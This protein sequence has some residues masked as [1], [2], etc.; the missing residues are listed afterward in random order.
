MAESSFEAYMTLA[1]LAVLTD[2]LRLGTAVSSVTHRHPAVLAKQVVTLDMVSGGRAVLGI[3]RGWAEDEHT[4]YGLP[5]GSA[6]QRSE[7]L[8]D[9]VS[10]CRSMFTEERSSFHGRHFQVVDAHNV[11]LPLSPFGPPI[12]I[13]GAGRKFTLPLVARFADIY[14]PGYGD[15]LLV[16]EVF[17]HLD[18]LCRQYGRNPGTIWRTQLKPVAIGS[19]PESAQGLWS[20]VERRMLEQYDPITGTHRDVVDQ[21]RPYVEAGVEGFIAVVPYGGTTP[22][23]IERVAAA[24]D[25]VLPAARAIELA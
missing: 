19:T 20:D 15:P 1:A 16:S 5:F 3:G 10:I 24:L 7:E 8:E 11:P 4:A 23:H 25:E 17:S 13:G 14:N 6:R 12:M 21:L 9:A 22:E 2:K 18:A